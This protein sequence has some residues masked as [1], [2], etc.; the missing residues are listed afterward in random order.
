M[1]HAVRLLRVQILKRL[2]P[3]C[4]MKSRICARMAASS[5]AP[6]PPRSSSQ[7]RRQERDGH[8]RVQ[9]FRQDS[10]PVARQNARRRAQGK[11][12]EHALHL[13]VGIRAGREERGRPLLEQ[14]QGLGPRPAHVPRQPYKEGPPG[15]AILW[16]ETMALSLSEKAAA[17]GKP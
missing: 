3:C 12:T 14:T 4:A 1:D 2:V 10:G 16:T 8:A 5:E 15:M 11:T 7:E 17:S 9:R 6:A 13:S